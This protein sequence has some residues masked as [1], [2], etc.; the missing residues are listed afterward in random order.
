MIFQSTQ[1]WFYEI[2]PH[3]N[4][5]NNNYKLSCQVNRWGQSTREEHREHGYELIIPWR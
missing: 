5:Q 3:T 1:P 2:F 4:G